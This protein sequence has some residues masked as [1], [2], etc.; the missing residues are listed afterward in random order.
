MVHEEVA[1]ASPKTSLS[2]GKL[3]TTIILGIILYLSEE[4][5]LIFE[6]S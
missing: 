5:D 2:E 6:L 3:L 1:S 4:R